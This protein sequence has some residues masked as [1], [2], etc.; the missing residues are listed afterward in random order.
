MPMWMPIMSSHSNS[1]KSDSN[2]R[3]NETIEKISLSTLTYNVWLTALAIKRPV[4]TMMIVMSLFVTGL[5]SSR[6]LPQESWPTVNIPMVFIN[7]PYNGATPEEVERLITRPVEEALATL[8]GIVEMTSKSRADSARIQIMMELSTDL[9]SKILEVREKIDLIKHLLPDDVQRVWVQKF[10]T[11]D[12]PVL[13]IVLSGEQ[14]LATAYD[15]L[16][17]KLKQPIERLKG[18]GNVAFRGVVRPHIEIQLNSTQ[19]AMNRVDQATLLRDLQASNFLSKSSTILDAGQKIRVI[20]DGQYHSLADIKNFQVKAGLK[21]QDIAKVHLV[22]FERRSEIRT[23]RKKSVG[24]EVF[25]ESDANVVKV[26]NMIVELVDELRQQ[27]DFKNINIAIKDNS[28]E[29]IQ[30]SLADLLQAG[31]VGIL[32]SFIILYIFL[33]NAKITFVVVASVP[34]SLSFA[35]AGMYF[36]GYTLNMLSLAGLF[37]AV[38]LLIDNS[39]VICESILQQQHKPIG[40]IKK[41]LAGVN[42][43]SIAIISGTLTTVIVFLPLLMGEKNFLTILIEQVAVAI[44]L[45]LIASLIIAKTVIP[46]MLSRIEEQSLSAI[47]THGKLDTWYRPKLMKVLTYPKMTALLI[48][49]LA[50]SAIFAKQAVDSSQESGKKEKELI[51]RYHIQGELKLADTSKIVDEM[52]AYLYANKADFQ[53]EQVNSRIWAGFAMSRIKLNEN[54]DIPLYQLKEKISKNFPVNAKARPSFDWAQQKQKRMSFTLTG[55]STKQLMDLSEGIILQLKNTKGFA[56]V[57]VQNRT[58]KQELALQIDRDKASRLGVSTQEIARRIATE[59]RGVNLRSFRDEKLGEIDIKLAFHPEETI[60][61]ASIKQLPIIEKEG[62]TITL[63]QLVTINNVP[64]MGVISRVNRQTNVSISINLADINRAK[65]LEKINNVMENVNFPSG[66]GWKS[67]N[68]F[69]QDEK[70]QKDMV[71]NML[72]AF[73]LIFIVMAALFESLLMPIAILSS[74][75]LAL[76]G[77]YWTF[78]LL[79]IGLGDTGMI[80]MLILMGIVVNNGIVLIDQINQ[81]KGS[82]DSLLQPIVDACV[83]RI[84]PIF[85][86]VATTVI[87]MAPLTF[88]SS[89]SQAYPMAVAIIGG[90]IFSTFTSLFLV[91]YC[92]LMLVKLGE[93]SSRRFQLAKAFADNI[94]RKSNSKGS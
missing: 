53:F 78:A 56:E 73:A 69:K 15:F 79:G 40:H 34:I 12:I 85:M 24:L 76:V 7:V 8:S 5:I 16:N 88:A 3:K 63:Q 50:V 18:V 19:L 89:N 37:I 52:E 77:V 38:G 43:V 90:L 28:G 70:A 45:P 62:R 41:I 32:L 2:E 66:Y 36:M 44:C 30:Q 29:E 4:T 48:L 14:N 93:R 65:A 33:R 23:D 13:N 42:S 9:D 64:V 87:G 81:Q 10:S 94:Y 22:S 6:L 47:S 25:K 67:G 51:I 17:T 74:I 83:S 59:L 75:L 55:R 82:S 61:L 57:A 80:G 71:T 20:P 11:D 1:D 72:L 39:V 49:L 21:L 84:R 92:Y 91:P 68:Q 35:V 27:E 46:L 54:Y 86:T 60:S 26:T 58:N 31:A